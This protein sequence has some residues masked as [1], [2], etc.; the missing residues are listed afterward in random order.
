M[1]TGTLL[2]IKQ[3][4]KR[5]DK[6]RQAVH[7][8]VQR[9]ELTRYETLR[10]ETNVARAVV[11]GLDSDEVNKVAKRL[12]SE[13]SMMDSGLW[14]QVIEVA[15]GLG[16]TTPRVHHMLS[17]GTFETVQIGRRRLISRASF[18]RCQAKRASA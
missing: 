7:E 9:G 8:M 5:L 11:I 14:M 13:Q 4:A 15:Q 17:A 10:Q 1:P 6:S 2:T 16:V 3:A 12:Q 18:E